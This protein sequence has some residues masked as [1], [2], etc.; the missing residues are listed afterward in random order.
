[1]RR[2]FDKQDKGNN[3]LLTVWGTVG[4][5]TGNLLIELGEWG[6]EVQQ[7]G[8]PQADKIAALPPDCL[9][10]LVLDG[11]SDEQLCLLPR[12]LDECDTQWVVLCPPEDAERDSVRAMITHCACAYLCL[13][14]AVTDLNAILR[15]AR[16]MATLRLSFQGIE[17]ANG[18]GGDA[19]EDEMVGTGPAMLDVFKT[20]RKVAAVDVPVLIRGESGTGK[21]LT[22]R[23]IHERS[24][25][26]RGAFIAVNCG[27]LPSELVQSELFGHEKGS[28]T[29]ATQRHVGHVE[30]AAGGTLL[31]DEIGDLPL[32][33]QVHLLRF[34]ETGRIQ[35][36]GGSEEIAVD[37]RILAATHVPLE[38][39]IEAGEFREDLYH[40]LN[41]VSLHLPPLREH[42]EDIE[43]LA[44]FFFERFAAERAAH[45]RGISTVAMQRMLQYDWPGN[46][47]ELINRM[48]R[49]TVMCEGRL[50]SPGD[51]DLDAFDPASEPVT[52]EAAR[53]QAECERIRAALTH[54]RNC[55]TAAARELGVSR[56]TLYRLIDKYDI[57]H[58]LH[59]SQRTNTG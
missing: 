17:D 12:Q 25:R 37:V 23:A 48:R 56:V 1:M 40:R 9:H 27:A 6:W 38:R 46:V 42:A 7:N 47:R 18:S 50:I 52:L 30:A 20:I 33:L 21:E 13:P 2:A 58:S 57:N 43:V 49:A 32:S 4:E 31:L 53:T 39:A 26:A 41:V 15:M 29:G 5:M 11:N 55:I 51:L 44:R 3:N 54:N 19:V 45:V 28:F 36:L 22:A 10:V 34:L 59:V 35:R 24:A 8:W 14:C 16:S